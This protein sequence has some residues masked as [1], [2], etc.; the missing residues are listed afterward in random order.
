MEQFSQKTRQL[1]HE[2]LKRS[3]IF[4]AKANSQGVNCF[5]FFCYSFDAAKL[6]IL[7]FILSSKKIHPSQRDQ[8][9]YYWKRWERNYIALHLNPPPLHGQAKKIR[10]NVS[11]HIKVF[12]APFVWHSWGVLITISYKPLVYKNMKNKRKRRKQLFYQMLKTIFWYCD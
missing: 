3:Q 11:F 1:F 4:I 6:Y 12:R 7:S 9:F 2:W 10:S 5:F 8:G